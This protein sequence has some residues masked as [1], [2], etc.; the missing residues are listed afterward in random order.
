MELNN[1][2]TTVRE[3]MAAP[4][5]LNFAFFFKN[6]K[7]LYVTCEHNTVGFNSKNT[8]IF[9]AIHNSSE[10]LNLHHNYSDPIN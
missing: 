7:K 4:S 6:Y 10:L 1:I 5:P 3:I 9:I 8:L 2:L